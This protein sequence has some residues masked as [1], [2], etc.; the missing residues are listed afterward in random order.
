MPSSSPSTLSP[1]PKQ[2]GPSPQREG[3]IEAAFTHLWDFAEKFLHKSNLGQTISR[4]FFA[5]N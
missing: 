3:D 2:P 4:P 1:A 5:H